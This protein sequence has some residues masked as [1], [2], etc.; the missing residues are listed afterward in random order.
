MHGRT[1]RDGRPRGLSQGRCLSPRP[2]A[3]GVERDGRPTRSRPCHPPELG[4]TRPPARSGWRSETTRVPVSRSS[5]A[6]RRCRSAVAASPLAISHGPPVNT[7]A[8]TSSRTRAPASVPSPAAHGRPYRPRTQQPLTRAAPVHR[9]HPAQASLPHQHTPLA[10]QQPT[11]QLTPPQRSAPQGSST[12]TAARNRT[13]PTSPHKQPVRARRTT[14]TVTRTE[15]QPGRRKQRKREGATVAAPQ[16]PPG[17]KERPQLSTLTAP[18]RPANRL[19]ERKSAFRRFPKMRPDRAIFGT[20]GAVFGTDSGV[21]GTS[22]AINGARQIERF[23]ASPAPA[24]PIAGPL[25]PPASRP[26]TSAREPSQ[27]GRVAGDVH[28]RTRV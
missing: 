24:A 20:G 9:S 2:T 4:A 16:A 8:G 27:R 15:P 7:P 13:Q 3:Q 21:F 12:P 26:T 11:G 18:P 17:I 6:R 5:R 14:Q 23:E 1:A 19:L 25:A 22:R 10:H 28:A